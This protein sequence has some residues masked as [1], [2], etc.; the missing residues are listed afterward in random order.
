MSTFGWVKIINVTKICKNPEFVGQ[1]IKDGNI[2][3]HDMTCA[4]L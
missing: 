4:L 3:T 1:G 2:I